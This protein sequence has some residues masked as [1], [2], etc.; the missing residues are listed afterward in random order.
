LIDLIITIIIVGI[1][2][3]AIINNMT[4]AAESHIMRSHP[5]LARSWTPQKCKVWMLA[6][7][8]PVQA[9]SSSTHA[10]LAW[11]HPDNAI[12]S[13]EALWLATSI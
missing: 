3:N 8:R 2:L 7:F 6:D 4:G 5:N 10:K 13:L 9:S 11:F 12:R 1:I